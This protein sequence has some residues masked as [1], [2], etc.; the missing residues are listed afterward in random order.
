MPTVYVCKYCGKEFD[1]IQALGGHIRM[2]H[3]RKRRSKKKAQQAQD[4]QA[5]AERKLSIINNSEKVVLKL[6]EAR[7]ELSDLIKRF[8]KHYKQPWHYRVP[9]VE[10]KYLEKILGLLD[11]ALRLLEPI[12]ET[13]KKRRKE[14]SFLDWLLGKSH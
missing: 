2:S 8:E 13:E 14:P 5:N 10:K 3:P 6:Y 11:S 12:R 1:S 7:S 4:Q 9:D